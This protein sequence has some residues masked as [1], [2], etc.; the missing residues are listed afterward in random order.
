M[1]REIITIPP[2]LISPLDMNWDIDWRGQSSGELGNGITQMVN[3]AFPRWVGSPQIFLRPDQILPWRAIRARARGRV[4]LYRIEICDPLGFNIADTGS[5][6]IS[7]GVPF[8][9]DVTFS[10][11][12]GLAYSPFVTC[13][14]GAAIGATEFTVSAEGGIP[15]PKVGQIMSFD[16]WPFMVV[17]A[18]DLGS[19]DFTLQIEMPLRSSIEAGG[20]I[21]LRA[22]G[23][24][25]ASDASAGNPSYGAA[26]FSKPTLKFM[27]YLNR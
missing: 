4:N 14:A 6:Y 21:D 13:A 25:E 19:G 1:K 5:S 20:L 23:L 26:H 24:F 17:A 18:D 10:T 3:S 12:Q 15:D 2:G 27:E 16:D 9:T 8:S 7:T 22:T 11:G